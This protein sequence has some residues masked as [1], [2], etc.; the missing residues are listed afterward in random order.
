MH[1]SLRRLFEDVH[2]CL[3]LET[4]NFRLFKDRIK[5]EELVSSSK[6]IEN[7]GLRH[8]DMLYLLEEIGPV[9]ST[10]SAV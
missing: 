4:Y 5:K 7:V 6:S 9:A 1:S 8:G 2:A 10:S 3:E